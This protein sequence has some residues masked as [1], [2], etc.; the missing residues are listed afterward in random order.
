MWPVSPAWPGGPPGRRYSARGT[1]AIAAV[2]VQDTGLGEQAG[3]VDGIKGGLEQGDV[4]AVGAVDGPA[5]R[6]AVALLESGWYPPEADTPERRLRHYARQFALVEVNA[7][8]YALPAEQTAAAWAARTPAG[9][10]FNVKAFSLFT[11]HPT[12]VAALPADLRPAAEKT[13][14]DRIYFTDVG[15]ALAGQVWSGS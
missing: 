9:F 7:T 15:P 4:V 14:K 2:E 5:D 1:G 3:V 12:P 6:D 8:Y 10:T 11:H 13:G